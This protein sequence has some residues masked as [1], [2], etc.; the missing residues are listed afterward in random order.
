MDIPY[1]ST[2]GVDI[3]QRRADPSAKGHFLG[4]PNLSPNLSAE[5]LQPRQ[6]MTISWVSRIIMCLPELRYARSS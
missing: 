6:M 2:Q 5:S 4:V 3:T 1:S